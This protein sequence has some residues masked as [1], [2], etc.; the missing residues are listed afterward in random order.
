MTARAPEPGDCCLPGGSCPECCGPRPHE[1]FECGVK[2]DS[3][4]ESFVRIGGK[5]RLV[6]EDCFERS[7]DPVPVYADEDLDPIY[8]TKEE[9]EYGR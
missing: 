6:C 2:V 4:E 8:D 5:P 1:C 7:G 9:A 3:L